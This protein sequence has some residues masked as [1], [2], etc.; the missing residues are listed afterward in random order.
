MSIQNGDTIDASDFV[1]NPSEF[2]SIESSAGAS[3][4][5]T[6]NG[7][8]RVL[9]F[10]SG[11]VSGDNNDMT[12]TL[13]YNGVGKHAVTLRS[14]VSS[15]GIAFS[16]MYTEIPAAGTQNITVTTNLGSVSDVVITVLKL[17]VI[18]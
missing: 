12:V 16:L 13:R 7:K 6:T 8:Q 4:S 11:R 17:R 10:A 3:H 14:G 2:F 5:L 9:V 15:Y 18:I 1:A